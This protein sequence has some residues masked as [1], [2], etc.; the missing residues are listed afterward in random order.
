MKKQ[1]NPVVAIAVIVVV[2]IVAVVLFVRKATTKKTR[3]IPGVGVMAED[4]TIK[5]PGERGARRGGGGAQ[6]G[7]TRRGQ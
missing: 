6:R 4:G 3:M 1:V 2:V 7:G 5:G